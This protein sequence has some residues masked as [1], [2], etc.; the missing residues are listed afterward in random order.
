VEASKLDID[1]PSDPN[2]L[3]R[4]VDDFVDQDR[5]ELVYACTDIMVV[6]KTPLLSKFPSIKAAFF[7]I[8]PFFALYDAKAHRCIGNRVDLRKY[9][10]MVCL[11]DEMEDPESRLEAF[12]YAYS[13]FEIGGPELFPAGIFVEAV[14]RAPF[15][16]EF[17]EE[18][19]AECV[20]NAID[21]TDPWDRLNWFASALVILGKVYAMQVRGWSVRAAMRLCSAQP[22]TCSPLSSIGE[23]PTEP[24]LSVLARFVRTFNCIIERHPGTFEAISENFLTHGQK[25]L[26]AIHA[27]G[28]RASWYADMFADTI[29]LA[30]PAL[31]NFPAPATIMRKLLI[32][33]R[34]DYLAVVAVVALGKDKDL[35]HYLA[36]FRRIPVKVLCKRLA[37]ELHVECDIDGLLD[38]A[39]NVVP[40]TRFLDGYGKS[41]N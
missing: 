11:F 15:A 24:V 28:Q 26:D 36:K 3:I 40:I 6:S 16:L 41:E 4:Q 33:R 25:A 23:A 19:F 31:F 39:M 7:I 27:G 29:E 18:R 20:L 5:W 13:A 34:F 21:E 30:I 22:S 35:H 8:E 17:L 10:D 1:R 38:L 2:V 37:F 9:M 14:E 12:K 32:E